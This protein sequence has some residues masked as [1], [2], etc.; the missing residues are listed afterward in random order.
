MGWFK[1]HEENLFLLILMMLAMTAIL[2]FVGRL[3]GT[4]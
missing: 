1:K 3:H 4:L 2:L